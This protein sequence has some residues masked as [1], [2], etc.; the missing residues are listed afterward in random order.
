MVVVNQGVF[1]QAKTQK[2]LDK[3]IKDS[4]TF[5]MLL[6]TEPANGGAPIEHF[7]DESGGEIPDKYKQLTQMEWVPLY[8]SSEMLP[9]SINTVLRQR[10]LAPRQE[11]SGDLALFLSHQQAKAQV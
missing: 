5:M 3:A 1:K 10:G 8:R 2:I 9:A 6:E 7:L 11:I 4:K